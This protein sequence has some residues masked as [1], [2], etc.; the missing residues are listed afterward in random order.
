MFSLC[1]HDYLL[2]TL[3]NE[4]LYYHHPNFNSIKRPCDIY[5]CD[6]RNHSISIFPAAFPLDFIIIIV[7]SYTRQFPPDARLCGSTKT[8]PLF[9]LLLHIF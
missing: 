6:L 1:M 7:I 9:L 2:W 5:K 4:H 3:K 8:L